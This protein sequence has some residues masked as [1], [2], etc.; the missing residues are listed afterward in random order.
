MRQTYKVGTELLERGIAN[1]MLF[2]LLGVVASIVCCH[3]HLCLNRGI[4]H[5]GTLS[6]TV[7][8]GEG[9]GQA[10]V[11]EIRGKMQGRHGGRGR[12]RRAAAGLV[13]AELVGGDPE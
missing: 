2:S 13:S 5:L 8:D 3:Q 7:S 4:A 6:P 10:W 11:S 9:R 1:A 12:G